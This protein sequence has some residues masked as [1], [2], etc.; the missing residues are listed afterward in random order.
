MIATFPYCRTEGASLTRRGVRKSETTSPLSS[1]KRS[2]S[3]VIVIFFLSLSWHRHIKSHTLRFFFGSFLTLWVSVLLLL[4]CPALCVCGEG[5]PVYFFNF[6]EEKKCQMTMIMSCVLLFEPLF[7][8]S[9]FRTL[10]VF[11]VVLVVIVAVDPFGRRRLG[12]RIQPTG[13][14]RHHGPSLMII[15]HCRPLFGS[16]VTT[17]T[18]TTTINRQS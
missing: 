16:T 4:L 18:T 8:S 10:S 5:R 13:V 11:G 3:V 2:S 9:F 1:Y 14:L 12:K 6:T 17:I 7:L 15:Q